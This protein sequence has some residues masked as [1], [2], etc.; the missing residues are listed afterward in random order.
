MFFWLRGV[1]LTNP[2]ALP[3]TLKGLLAAPEGPL[4]PPRAP[5]MGYLQHMTFSYLDTKFLLD[6][7]KNMDFKA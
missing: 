1:I 6:I 5:S 4:G 2:R 7:L 3:K